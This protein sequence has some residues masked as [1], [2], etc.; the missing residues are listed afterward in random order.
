MK[1]FGE[2]VSTPV[3]Y[4]ATKKLSEVREY[5]EQLSENKVEIFPFLVAEL[6]FIVKSSRTDLETA[7][8]FLTTRGSKSDIDD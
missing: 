3:S 2:D 1:M 5:A 7:V 8:S 4:P 6:L